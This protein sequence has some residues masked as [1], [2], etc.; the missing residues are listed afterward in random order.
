M[1]AVI[2]PDSLDREVLAELRQLAVE[3]AGLNQMV[4]RV[5]ERLGFVPE[6][7][8]PVFPYFCTAFSLPLKEV[9]PL[10][11]YSKNRDVPELQG[12]LTKIR[13]AEIAAR[14]PLIQAAA[15]GSLDELRCPRCECQTVSVYF[16]RPAPEEY[17][18][19][20]VCSACD[21]SMRTQ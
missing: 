4:S 15:D 20:F 11:E 1:A 9:L 7:I 10:R 18:T 13:Q 17:R 2:I 14:L 16:T 6:F 21:F 19:W 12:L 8:V 3:G 5:Q